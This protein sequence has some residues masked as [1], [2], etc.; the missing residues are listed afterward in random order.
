MLNSIAEDLIKQNNSALLVKKIFVLSAL[1]INLEKKKMFNP[2]LTSNLTNITLSDLTKN[3]TLKTLNTL[4][5]S[6][7]SSVADKILINPWKGAEA[8][9]LYL[10]CL[11]YLK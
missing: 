8:W 11:R 5:T 3:S 2:N 7:I 10:M 6:D 1:E 4:I 9:H